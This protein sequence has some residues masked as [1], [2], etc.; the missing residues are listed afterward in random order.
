MGFK[1]D[2]KK[3]NLLANEIYVHIVFKVLVELD[4]VWVILIKLGNK[5]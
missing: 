5:C 3:R 1:T 2:S 4:D